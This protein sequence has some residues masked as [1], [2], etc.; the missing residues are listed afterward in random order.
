[1]ITGFDVAGLG[2]SE[3]SHLR[4]EIDRVMAPDG[5]ER[6][7][8]AIGL[9][10]AVMKSRPGDGLDLDAILEVYSAELKNLP[11]VAV[12]ESCRQ[13]ARTQTFF[14]ALAEIL[15]AVDTW[16]ANYRIA[17]RAIDATIPTMSRTERPVQ[18]S[19][20]QAKNSVLRDMGQEEFD[21]RAAVVRARRIAGEAVDINLKFGAA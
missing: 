1:M 16:T 9:M 10:H 2:E 15:K 5:K 21:R 20:I 14:P 18:V 11:G 12:E 17:Q 4:A 8:R 6:V 3:R 13:L 7:V 19:S